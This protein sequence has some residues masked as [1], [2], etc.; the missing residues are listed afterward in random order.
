MKRVNIQKIRIIYIFN[1]KKTIFDKIVFNLANTLVTIQILS[2]PF[3][4]FLVE[5]R[6]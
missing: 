3:Y 2:R 6:S 5:R 4:R 1:E